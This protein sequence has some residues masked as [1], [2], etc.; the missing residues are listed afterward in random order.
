MKKILLALIMI[1]F[2]ASTVFAADQVITIRIPS[3]KVEKALEGFLTIYPNRETIPDPEWVDPE[4]GSEAPQIPK[5]SN[6]SWVVEKVRRLIVR[7]VRRGLQ[8]KKNRDNIIEK[9]DSMAVVE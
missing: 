3:G 8:M 5:Y 9:D 2:M 6:K 7:D 1:C 4:D